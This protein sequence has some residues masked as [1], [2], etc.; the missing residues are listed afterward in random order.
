M[1]ALKSN[2]DHLKNHISHDCAFVASKPDAVRTTFLKQLLEE[3][4]RYI[5]LLADNSSDGVIRSSP[6]YFVDQAFHCLMLDP[7]LYFRVC[8][9]ILSMQGQDGVDIPALPHDALGGQGDDSEPRKARYLDT[10]DRYKKIFG[11]DPPLA[12]WTDYSNDP[13]AVTTE[14][15]AQ[16]AQQA[17]ASR[18][19]HAQPRQMAPSSA[20]AVLV[21]SAVS[22]IP[23]R[24]NR[25]EDDGS[26]TVVI[27]NQAGNT[28]FYKI[29]RTSSLLSLCKYYAEHHD[30]KMSDLRFTLDGHSFYDETARDLGLE[31][32][33]QI[34][35]LLALKGC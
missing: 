27:K 34:D 5:Y 26:V 1:G 11:Q 16:Q 7:S 4:F 29:M 9:E 15:E 19:H 10:L 35:V 18:P 3:L 33:D 31:D 17:V 12:L 6:S 28:N 30:L 25:N 20:A 23:Q 24:V 14:F 2:F 21:P 8:R 22:P 32:G 13:A